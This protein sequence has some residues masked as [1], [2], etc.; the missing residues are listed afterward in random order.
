LSAGSSPGCAE[1][2][3]D[4]Q[5]LKEGVPTG[6]AALALP[7][8][9]DHASRLVA[10]H[11]RP[12]GQCAASRA[13]IPACCQSVGVSDSGGQGSGPL[14]RRRSTQALLGSPRIVGESIHRG[15]LLPNCWVGGSLFRFSARCDRQHEIDDWSHTIRMRSVP[16][17][18]VIT[19]YCRYFFAAASRAS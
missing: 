4:Q 19:G 3:L 17:S 1:T 11:A 2:C 8:M 14:G 6:V 9:R 16:A 12:R 13:L 15:V 10:R 5:R 18:V 7:M